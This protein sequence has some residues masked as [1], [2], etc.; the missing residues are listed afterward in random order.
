MIINLFCYIRVMQ[1][2]I[3]IIQTGNK[4]TT[5]KIH[6]PIQNQTRISLT[7]KR[8]NKQSLKQIRETQIL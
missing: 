8:I 7:I 1:K 5:P 3:V 2:Y 6:E 4:N